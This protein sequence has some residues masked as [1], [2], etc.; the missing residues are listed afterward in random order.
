M[1]AEDEKLKNVSLKNFDTSSI[2][3]MAN[4]FLDCSAM[5]KISVGNKWDITQVN[6]EG[7]A[8]FMFSGCGVEE[9]TYQ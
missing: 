6:A 2:P 9:V 5:Q 4:M 3:N 1:F 7:K 8:F